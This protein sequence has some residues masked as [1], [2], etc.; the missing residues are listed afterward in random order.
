MTDQLEIR[1]QIKKQ[2][3]RYQ[4]T[5][6]K[7]TA[8]S[9]DD[10]KVLCSMVKRSHL[11]TVTEILLAEAKER[12]NASCNKETKRRLSKMITNLEKI[13]ADFDRDLMEKCK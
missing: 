2:F 9:E 7:L 6:K 8:I 10:D 5:R 3:E 11:I 13:I 1:T 12:K 4:T